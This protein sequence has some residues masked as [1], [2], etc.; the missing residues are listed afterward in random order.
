MEGNN[1]RIDAVKW[2]FGKVPISNQPALVP[3]IMLYI[4]NKM[5]SNLVAAIQNFNSFS[6]KSLKIL[7]SWSWVISRVVESCHLVLPLCTI[8]VRHKLKSHFHPSRL[9]YISLC[10]S[11]TDPPPS[12]MAPPE[13][14]APSSTNMQACTTNTRPTVHMVTKSLVMRTFDLTL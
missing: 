11:M 3:S 14:A 10:G 13:A 9:F 1:T 8:L 6:T 7:Y 4:K 2:D 5:D 12:T